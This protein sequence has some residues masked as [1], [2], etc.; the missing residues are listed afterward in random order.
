MV[1]WEVYTYVDRLEQTEMQTEY[2]TSDN[3]HFLILQSPL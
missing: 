2:D 3:G 1:E